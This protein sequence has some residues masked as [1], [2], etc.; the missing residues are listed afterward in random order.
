MINA[1]SAETLLASFADLAALLP[2]FQARGE[3][4]QQRLVAAIKRWLEQCQQRWL[5]IFD[6]ADDVSLIQDA[7]PQGGHGSILLTTRASAVGALAAPIEI[8]VMGFVEG[9]QLL[10]R[11]AQRFEGISDEEFNQAG[12]IVVALDHFPLALDQAGAYIEETGCGFAGYL[13]VY[14]AH[15]NELLARRGR[16]LI[17]Y[18]AS[19]MT[20]WSLSF[21]KVK[22]ANPAAAELLCLCAFLAPDAIPEELITEGV[23]F[24]GPLLQQQVTDLFLF[25]EM[26]SE[27]LKF[28]LVQRL[29]EARM[30]RIH[31]LVQAALMSTLDGETQRQ[32]AKAIV[33]AVNQ[34][35]PRDPLD[36]TVWPQC[37][38][39]LDQ[40]QTSSMWI[41]TACVFICRGGGCPVSNRCLFDK[42]CLLPYPPCHCTSGPSRSE[43]NAWVPTT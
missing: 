37:L 6:N 42:A 33:L 41:R 43:N 15:R 22:A 8:E 1:A 28:S 36:I 31:R 34:V 17:D 16:T 25:N 23:P 13:Q 14:S 21:Q 39:Y 10:L 7:V 3:K 2:G 32:W 18:P 27:L 40:V 5:L 35:F 12:N 24:L 9:T 4:D 11:R 19:V 20:T 26:V 38:R 30:L 29:A